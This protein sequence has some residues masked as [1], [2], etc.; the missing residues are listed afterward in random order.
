MEIL[1][2]PLLQ[3]ARIRLNMINKRLLISCV[4]VIAAVS[5][6]C[7]VWS[8]CSHSNLIEEDGACVIVDGSRLRFS[9]SEIV[10][11]NSL[12]ISVRPTQKT[13]EWLY[14]YAA[15]S[16]VLIN[17]HR[18]SINAKSIKHVYVDSERI[19]D[20]EIISELPVLFRFFADKVIVAG[21][22]TW[23]KGQIVIENADDSYDVNIH[24]KKNCR[25]VVKGN[26]YEFTG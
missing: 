4:A 23:V 10:V 25:I 9:N 3:I 24:V 13:S 22:A 16:E 18:L 8:M 14:L 20:E 6:G 19:L 26:W 1:L 7:Y 11:T 15:D 2:K 12:S 5:G 17:G 21:S